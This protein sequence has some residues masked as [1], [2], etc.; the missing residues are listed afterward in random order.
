MVK[1]ID[2]DAISS[3]PEDRLRFLEEFTGFTEGD[4]QAIKESAGLLA[5]RLE[6]LVEAVYD[7]LL[8]FDDTRRIFARA[9]SI[10]PDVLA[11][12]KRH[13]IGWVCMT[14][15]AGPDTRRDFA[16]YLNIVGRRHTA[17][18]G[19]AGH[20]VPPRYLV[21]M[22]SYIQ[23]ALTVALFE[24]LPDEPERALRYAVAWNKMVMMQLEMFLK[25]VAPQWPRWDEPGICP[26]AWPHDAATIRLA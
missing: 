16:N 7:H 1:R 5:P 9:G 11:A 20:A 18:E 22:T 25:N 12:R 21:G 14:A 15:A 17:I 6:A 2:T 23:S 8:A 24:V 4:W 10:D 19:D 26:G 3:R 13:L